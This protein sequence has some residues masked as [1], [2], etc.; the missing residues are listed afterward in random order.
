MT[1]S[2][3]D[4]KDMLDLASSNSIKSQLT[5][6]TT[7]AVETFGAFGAPWLVAHKDDGTEECFFGSDRFEALAYFMG[8]PWYG[9]VPPAIPSNKL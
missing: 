8:K 4:A 7:T 3:S 5:K 9:P 1:L 2:P 6:N